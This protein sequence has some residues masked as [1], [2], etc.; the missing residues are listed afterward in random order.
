VEESSS[1]LIWTLVLSRTDS[2]D[3][4]T[5]DHLKKL[6]RKGRIAA[7]RRTSLEKH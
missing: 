5:F 6:I 4:I 3:I 7:L 2:K 1:V